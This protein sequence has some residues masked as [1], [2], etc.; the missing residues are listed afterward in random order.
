VQLRPVAITGRAVVSGGS[1]LPGVVV[2]LGNRHTTVTGEDGRFVLDGVD[3]ADEGPV[4]VY[5][6]YGAGRVAQRLEKPTKVS[7]AGVVDQVVVDDL[8]FP[9]QPAAGRLVGTVE[10]EE[11]ARVP[12]EPLDVR[13]FSGREAEGLPTHHATIDPGVDFVFEAVEA[14]PVFVRLESEDGRVAEQQLTMPE[15]GQTRTQPFVL[16]SGDEVPPRITSVLPTIQATGVDPSQCTPDL[17]PGDVLGANVFDFRTQSF[18]LTKGPVFTEFLLVDEVNRTPPKTQSALLE[19]MQERSVTIDGTTH[20][21]PPRFIVIATQNPVEHEGTYPLPEAQLDRFLFKLPVGYPPEQ[22]EVAA[23]VAHCASSGMPDLDA[24]GIRPLL[25]REELD[26]LAQVPAAVRV[27]ESVARYAV[28]LA[29]ATREHPS[30]AVGLSTRAATMVTAAARGAAA[31]AGR[32]YVVP[33]DVKSLFVAAARHRV[34]LSVAAEMEG[35]TPD[36]VVAELLEQVAA[37][38]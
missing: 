13:L 33:D 35:V 23:V 32:D 10:A 20:V 18:V 4:S 2:T 14:G 28:A 34:L 5:A 22:E 29:R 1:P 21:L 25:R 12:A 36:E 16:G 8:E 27:E 37:P 30:L 38:R 24:L 26:A 6:V 9:P 7:L 3:L 15:G 17:M 31:C 19:A 11:G